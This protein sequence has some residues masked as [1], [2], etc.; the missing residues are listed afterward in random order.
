[1]LST[2][3]ETDT[4]NALTASSFADSQIRHIHT[5]GPTN[6]YSIK[7]CKSVISNSLAAHIRDKRL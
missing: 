7:E 4:S 3:D 2:C 6:E 1:M 5:M